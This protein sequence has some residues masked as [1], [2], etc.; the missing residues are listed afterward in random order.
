MA[1][2]TRNTCLAA[3]AA[4]TFAAAPV[5]AQAPAA[6][7][8]GEWISLSGTVESV[9]GENFVLDYGKNNIMVE[10]DDYDWYNENALLVGDEVTVTGRIDNDFVMSRRIE[11]SSVYVD[12][13]HTRFY[14]SAADEEDYVPVMAD[15]AFVGDTGI[16]LTGTVE[17]IAGDEMIVDAAFFDYKVDTGTLHYNPFDAAG[18]QHVAVGDR[19]SVS[20]QFDDSDFFDSPEIDATALIEIR[21]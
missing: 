5:A 14:A 9:A 1:H 19:V 21:S 2:R 12:S 11:A 8:D 15:G 10:M 20:G 16:T 6:K 7:S 4:L 17:S 18:L 3:A 13:I